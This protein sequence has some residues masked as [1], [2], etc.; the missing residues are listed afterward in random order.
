MG[1]N[2]DGL[3]ADF[4]DTSHRLQETLSDARGA[5]NGAKLPAVSQDARALVSKLS[6][7]AL[8]LR[9]RSLASVDSGE[10][11]SSLEEVRAAMDKC[12]S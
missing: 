2:A 5:I 1:T 4:R 6:T 9:R 11:N 10:L 7:L 8:E 3:I 12:S